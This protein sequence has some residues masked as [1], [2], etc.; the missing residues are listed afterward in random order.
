MRKRKELLAYC[1]SY[2]GECPEYTG[3]I[4]DAAGELMAKLEAHRYDRVASCVFPG[5]LGNLDEFSEMLSFIS[6]LRCPGSCRE[7]LGGVVGCPV[8]ECCIERGF[9]ACYECEELDSCQEL[10]SLNQGMHVE[11]SLRNLRDIR[12]VGLDDW[13]YSKKSPV[14]TVVKP[15]VPLDEIQVIV[16]AENIG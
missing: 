16:G 3:E 7:S 6:N 8:K 4:A 9:F 15:V 1:G 10:R 12:A 5:K 13:I 2:C 11:N 14:Y